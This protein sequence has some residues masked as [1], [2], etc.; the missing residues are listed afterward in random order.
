MGLISW[1]LD[2]RAAD[3]LVIG[4]SEEFIAYVLALSPRVAVFDC[5]GTL[6][7]MNSG[8]KFFYLSMPDAASGR[9]GLVAEDTA[10][11]LRNRYA[12][13]QRGEVGEIAMCG[14]M[15]SMYAGLRIAP[16]RAAAE[17]FV[18]SSVLASTFPEML[19]LT[20]QLRQQGC[21]LWAVSSSTEWLI[22]PGIRSFGIPSDHVLATRLAV[23]DGIAGS[24]LL[25]IPSD[26]NKATVIAE[27]IPRTVDAA[28]GNSIHDAAMLEIATH[29]FAV[30]PTP[31]LEELAVQR[32]WKIY[33][34]Q[35]TRKKQNRRD[36]G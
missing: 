24:E 18:A 25:S 34:P 19:G 10:H 3:A 12:Q 11:R 5:D 2:R 31:E 26:A 32:G 28:F 27:R 23:R 33:W 6:W 20:L 13:Y 22:E 35:A 7:E 1:R 29:A 21:E 36:A 16:V 8:E 14:E 30:N 15:V 9:K 4:T 17:S